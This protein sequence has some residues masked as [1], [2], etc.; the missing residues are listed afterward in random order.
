MFKR[1]VSRV[2]LGAL[3]A[4]V[5]LVAGA[6]AAYAHRPN[7]KASILRLDGKPNGFIEMA[8]QHNGRISLNLPSPPAGGRL[9]FDYRKN[10]S[11]ETTVTYAITGPRM[12]VLFGFTTQDQDKLELT[13]L[14]VLDANDNV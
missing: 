10:A 6:T 2:L 9:V 5:L 4:S 1:G 13:N 12:V 8:P 7:V 3:V 14:R 11:P